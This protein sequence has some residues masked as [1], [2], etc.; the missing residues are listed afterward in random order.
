MQYCNEEAP[1]TQSL[2]RSHCA[3]LGWP[4]TQEVVVVVV[5]EESATQDVV[6]VVVMD[7]TGG[8]WPRNPSPVEGGMEKRCA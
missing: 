2:W 1:K 8:I 7:E 6:V 5:I 3:L 4:V